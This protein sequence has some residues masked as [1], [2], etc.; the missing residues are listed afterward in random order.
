MRLLIPTIVIAGSILAAPAAQACSCFCDDSKQPRN[1]IER[2]EQARQ[3]LLNFDYVF[4]GEV[5][6]IGDALPLPAEA[7]PFATPLHS[8]TIRPVKI[9]KGPQAETITVLARLG[10]GSNCFNELEVGGH[11]RGLAKRE[12]DAWIA[13]NWNCDCD[14]WA[15]FDIG[16][17]LDDEALRK[18]L[19]GCAG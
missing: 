17:R 14:N 8:V 16:G 12:G 1:G 10:D 6:A 18:S 11:F 19:Y 4:L 2:R 13:T 7:H 3:T 9:A 15:I 5:V